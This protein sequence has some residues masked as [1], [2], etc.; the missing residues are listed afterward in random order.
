MSK[1]PKL[2]SSFAYKHSSLV[3]KDAEVQNH[4][5]L[6]GVSEPLSDVS[7]ENME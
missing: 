7:I 5:I 4:R 3:P 6:V 2:S 1:K